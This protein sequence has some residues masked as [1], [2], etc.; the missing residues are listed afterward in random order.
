MNWVQKMFSER[1][2]IKVN[3]IA[4]SVQLA[5]VSACPMNQVW[6]GRQR[7]IDQTE[8]AYFTTFDFD[9]TAD[10]EIELF[11][12]IIDTVEIRP[13]EFGINHVVDGNIIKFKLRE[14]LHFTVEVNGTHHALHVFS[15]HA[16]Q[17]RIK[18]GDIYFGKGEH[19]AGLIS[20][21]ENQTIFIDEG[22]V[23][24]GA[25]FVNCVDNVKIIGRGILDSSRLK[26]G[27][28]A[29]PEEDGGEVA[30]GLKALGF[31]DKDIQYTGALVALGCKNLTID[32]II[33]RDSMFWTLIIR[34]NCQNILI[35]NVKIIGQWRYNSDGIN[36]CNSENVLVRNCFIRSFDD[37]FV[38][39][40]AYLPGEEG[41]TRNVRV[42]N[43]VMWCDWGKNLEI[44]AGDKPARIEDI[45][46]SNNYLIH[47][48]HFAI[49]ITAWF[50]SADTYIGN[51]R[52]QNIFID[53]DNYYPAP[54]MQ[55][56]DTQKYECN[57][58]SHEP[59]LLWIGCGKLGKNAGNQVH[60]PADNLSLYHLH[61][62]KIVVENIHIS[63]GRQKLKCVINAM[64]GVLEINDVTL[65]NIENGN[66]QINGS[67]HGVEI[68]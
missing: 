61:Y 68:Q 28:E 22:A 54:M 19:F 35:D 55:K 1:F 67:V 38:A 13:L 64:E 15:S 56:S 32:G 34:N 17:Y 6:N 11:G 29:I 31:N 53:G 20:P 37:C 58:D 7:N 48:S 30:K 23:V 43:C 45:T 42:E 14:P 18:D 59:V 41:N 65:K 39:R 12:D 66:V 36:I 49:D 60:I 40:G 57:V 47:L 8:I 16:L 5:R 63:G 44:W 52:Y 9:D 25:I 4:I 33:I 26:R 2:T 27:I 46:F 62:E 3:G 50:G 10:V 51:I 21:K 24:Y